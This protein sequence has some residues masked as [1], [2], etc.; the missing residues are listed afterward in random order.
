MSSPPLPPLRPL[1]SF[2]P[3]GR[4]PKWN[5]LPSPFL[6][7][8]GRCLFFLILPSFDPLSFFS[9]LRVFDGSLLFSNTNAPLS[10]GL[11][12]MGLSPFASSFSLFFRWCSLGRTPSQWSYRRWRC[13]SYRDRNWP[14]VFPPRFSPPGLL[15]FLSFPFRNAGDL[16]FCPALRITESTDGTSFPSLSRAANPFLM[17]IEPLPAHAGGCIFL[18]R[19]AF[20]FS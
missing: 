17:T 1:F 14:G 20:S 3:E 16:F 19:R 13:C 11:L 18:F 9:R 2:L 15:F 4:R 7:T 12:M 10:L 8:V 6:D 5:N